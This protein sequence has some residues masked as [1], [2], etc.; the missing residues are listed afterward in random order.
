MEAA[1]HSLVTSGVVRR[2]ASWR[3]SERA[4]NTGPQVS[5][6]RVTVS[7]RGLARPWSWTVPYQT[8]FRGRLRFA[9]RGSGEAEGRAWALGLTVSTVSIFRIA[10][11]R[12]LCLCAFAFRAQHRLKQPACTCAPSPYD[13]CSLAS[14]LSAFRFSAARSTCASWFEPR[15]VLS[16]RSPKRALHSNGG[17]RD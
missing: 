1:H 2:C 17:N 4:P 13:L 12:T 11:I 8:D 3:P 10:P 16:C 5:E 15:A 14:T 9:F 6:Q 7:V